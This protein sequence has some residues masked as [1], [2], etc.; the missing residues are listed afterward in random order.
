MMLHRLTKSILSLSFLLLLWFMHGSCGQPIPPT[1][2]P[3]DTLPPFFV[4]A[5]PK[6]SAV[7]VKGNRIILNFNEYI[8]VD[9]AYENVIV[10]PLPKS[11]PQVDGKLKQVIIKLRDT[12]EPNTTYTIDFGN[13]IRD[14]NENNILRHYSY[15]F[16]TGDRLDSARIFGKVLLAESGMPD[17]TLTVVLHRSADDSAIAKDRPRYFTKSNAKGEFLFK[18]LAAGAYHIFALKDVDNSRK[19]DQASEMI[20]FLEKPVQ[21][22]QEGPVQLYAFQAAEEKKQKPLTPTKTPSP[23]PPKQ[24]KDDKRLKYTNNLDNGQQDLLGPFTLIFERPF[25]RMDTSKLLL[26]DEKFNRLPRY[27]ISTDTTNTRVTISNAWKEGEHYK[28]IVQKDLA[29]DSLGNAV[30]RTDTIAINAHRESD[31]ASIDLKFS[32]LDT[33]LHPVLILMA[34]DKIELSRPVDAQ[35]IRYKLFRPGDYEVRILYDRN[36]NGIWDTGD[37]W[38]K[39]QPEKVLS[40]PQKWNA[41]SNMDNEIT[42]DLGSGFN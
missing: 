30:M 28:L 25:N 7:N 13:S 11:A 4:G 14:I 36:R 16:S 9:R 37:Y 10:S 41:R 18:G 31:Y 42:I 1:G 24:N 23:A 12:L 35:R 15:T 20:G 17:S 8:S 22:G 19:Y 40:R 6:D 26:T 34:N 27:T 29:G 5:E 38:K 39:I 21:A 2:G 3:R 32:N 33:S